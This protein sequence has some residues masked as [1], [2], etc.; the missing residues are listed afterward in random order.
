MESR[1]R[2]P[3]TAV[4]WA[5]LCPLQPSAIALLHRY[6]RPAQLVEL[7][8]HTS[9]TIKPRLRDNRN[10]MARQGVISTTL[11]ITREQCYRWCERLDCLPLAT[12]TFFVAMRG[13]FLHGSGSLVPLAILAYRTAFTLATVVLALVEASLL[14]I[15]FMRLDGEAQERRGFG[16]RVAL[17]V[18]L[19]PAVV[20]FS[21]LMAWLGFEV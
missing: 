4:C 13:Y 18:T 10:I 2:C 15:L 19:A 21:P 9:S 12:L 3:F 20:T 7:L 8:R 11:G 1:L 17:I 5:Q 14:T 16:F 6:R